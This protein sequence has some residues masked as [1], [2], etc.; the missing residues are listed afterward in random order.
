MLFGI[1]NTSPITKYFGIVEQLETR[2][3]DSR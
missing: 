2:H 3:S 1:R